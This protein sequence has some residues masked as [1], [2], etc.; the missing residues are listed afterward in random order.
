MTGYLPH[1]Q[2]HLELE[3]F[4][5]SVIDA[6][7]WR[8]R[9]QHHIFFSLL[10][11]GTNSK[12]NQALGD[13]PAL[14]TNLILK[15]SSCAHAFR[16]RQTPP[17]LTSFLQI[18]DSFVCWHSKHRT[19]CTVNIIQCYQLPFAFYEVR[20]YSSCRFSSIQNNKTLWWGRCVALLV[21]NP[22]LWWKVCLFIYYG[23][24]SGFT[25][26][27]LSNTLKPKC[28][29]LLLILLSQSHVTLNK[30]FE[31]CKWRWDA[32]R[33]LNKLFYCIYFA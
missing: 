16:D 9:F 4:L 18:V 19:E 2:F 17:N 12:L 31:R 6:R 21:R 26:E 29:R 10:L 5:E 20:R 22:Y 14:K 1:S 33:Q 32:K 25:I 23:Q 11:A 30:A 28:P 27:P 24:Q 15:P 7:C 3:Q 8:G 13:G